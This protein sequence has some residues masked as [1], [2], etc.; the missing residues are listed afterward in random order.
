MFS[1]RISGATHTLGA[2]K[3]WS[4]SDGR[5]ANLTVRVADD[6]WESAWEPTPAELA[7]LNEGGHVILCVKGG[8][9]PVML[10]AELPREDLQK[11]F[12]P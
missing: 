3:G 4:Q 10:Y 6:C 9:P 8:Q 5:C 7:A 1:K 11:G 2:P 12:I